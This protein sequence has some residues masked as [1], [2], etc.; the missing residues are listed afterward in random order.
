MK[1]MEHYLGATYSHIYQPAI[2]N[3]TP[4]TFP[5]PDITTII[6]DKGVEHPKMDTN[7]SYF[8]NNNID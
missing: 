4:E 7:I 1:D 3:N 5:G 8:E 2:T 6:P